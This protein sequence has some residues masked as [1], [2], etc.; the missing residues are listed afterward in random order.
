MPIPVSVTATRARRPPS[1]RR[2]VMVIRPPSF[3]NLMALESRWSRIWRTRILSARMASGAES[4]RAQ[5][6]QRRHHLD[7][8]PPEAPLAIRADK[9]RVRQILL[10]L[11]G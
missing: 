7:L 4:V 1:S 11:Q 5:L 6:E 3:V 8:Q 2:A 10:N 9:I